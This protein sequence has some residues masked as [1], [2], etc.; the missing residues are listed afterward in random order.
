MNHIIL[1]GDIKD[2]L[3]RH[4]CFQLSEAAA[5]IHSAHI[6]VA[7]RDIKPANVLFV[8]GHVKL[9]DFGLAKSVEMSLQSATQCGSLHWMAP[10][11]L[12][13]NQSLRDLKAC[14]IF[15][16]GCVHFYILTRGGHPFNRGKERSKWNCVVSH[17]AIDLSGISS[18][19]QH[20]VYK[21]LQQD[22][23]MRP[24][25]EWCCQVRF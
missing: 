16:L 25:A 7:H 15:S 11:L 21:L 23:Q 6:N 1:D 8:D 22:P 9:C 4:F 12:E 20:I 14:D 5:H 2:D 18:T 17:D 3:A 19:A 10:E 13:G 24:A